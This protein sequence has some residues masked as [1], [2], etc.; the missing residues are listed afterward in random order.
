MTIRCRYLMVLVLWTLA[1]VALGLY[2]RTMTLSYDE[3]ISFLRPAQCNETAS[4]AVWTTGRSS[5]YVCYIAISTAWCAD[6]SV[7]TLSHCFVGHDVF[8]LE[9]NPASNFQ[10]CSFCNHSFYRNPPETQAKKDHPGWSND[11]APYLS[12]LSAHNLCLN[13]MARK[14]YMCWVDKRDGTLHTEASVFP[15][16][17]VLT[18][19]VLATIYSI[20]MVRKFAQ[21]A[22]IWKNIDNKIPKQVPST[23]DA[24]EVGLPLGAFTLQSAVTMVEFCTPQCIVSECD[25]VVEMNVQ[26]LGQTAFEVIVE[27]R[28]TNR[29]LDE[30]VYKESIGSLVFEPTNNQTSV[31]DIHV[32]S[33]GE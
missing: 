14:P 2:A 11:Y 26:M 13:S 17:T 31:S 22:Q 27:Y 4:E 6:D 29:S 7:S 33:D 10:G 5:T 8:E 32:E 30:S 12:H 16:A 28:T 19:C 9:R 15:Y 21:F 20:Y 3:D 25:D 24:P 18:W 1:V 23:I